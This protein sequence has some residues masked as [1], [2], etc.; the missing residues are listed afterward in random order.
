MIVDVQITLKGLNQFGEVI[1]GFLILEGPLV[2][3]TLSDWASQSVGNYE[4]LWYELKYGSKIEIM[5]ADLPLTE[6][7]CINSLGRLEPTTKRASHEDMILHIEKS[8][9]WCLSVF[10]RLGGAR[11]VLI[12]G[13]SA[14]V[15]GAYERLG[16][17]QFVGSSSFQGSEILSSSWF[18]DAN[19]ATV[20][21]V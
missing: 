7:V 2:S 19:R 12:L 17:C 21:T 16:I 4:G 10:H 11:F 1:D 3:A 6:G 13:L 20:K 18:D 15:P 14:R 5:Q 8:P 9:V